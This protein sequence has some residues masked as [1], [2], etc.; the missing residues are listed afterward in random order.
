MKTNYVITGVLILSFLL[1]ALILLNSSNNNLEYYSM[2]ASTWTKITKSK[3]EQV[4]L[5]EA[6]NYAFK[7]NYPRFLIFN[8][9]CKGKETAKVK[10]YA[11]DINTFFGT[12]AVSGECTKEDE[13]CVINLG[14][15]EI[16]LTFDELERYK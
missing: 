8:C 15:E 7:N 3:I 14:S 4:C 5:R 13:E 10:E 11:C 9:A 2:K 1:I 12:Y 16:D 6:R